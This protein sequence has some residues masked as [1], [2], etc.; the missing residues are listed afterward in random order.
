MD[1]HVHL[2]CW[3]F[4]LVGVFQ[5]QIW[6]ESSLFSLEQQG[7]QVSVLEEILKKTEIFACLANLNDLHFTMH[8][9]FHLCP[10]ST[11]G[12]CAIHKKK[13]NSEIIG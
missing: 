6:M 9:E 5:Y 2:V 8:C 4:D 1:P 7:L 10:R 3:D 13:P 11:T 12:T